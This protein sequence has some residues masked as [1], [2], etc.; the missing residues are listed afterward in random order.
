MSTVAVHEAEAASPPAGISDDAHA[1]TIEIL[2]EITRGGLAGLITGVVV[3]G[4][5]GRLVM[6]L[7]ALLVPTSA[8]AHTEN[9]NVIGAITL[10]GSLALIVFAGL[11]VG[12]IAG[13]VWVMIAPWLPR[14]TGRRM[15]TAAL[16]AG[17]LGAPVL[18]QA[19]NIDFIVLRR[20]PL[21]VA[22]L[23][24]LVLLAGPVLVAA[25]RWLDG[26]LPRPPVRTAIDSAYA[27]VAALG[28]VLTVFLVIPALASSKVAIA[29]LAILLVG[30][31]TLLTWIQRVRGGEPADP[32]L[33]VIVRGALVVAVVTGL[34]VAFVEVRG[35][36]GV[37]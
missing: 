6:R 31:A 23:I 30:F 19:S 7:A 21:V 17:A 27:L 3:G 33:A 16:V 29:G 12:A 22:S 13:S 15:A 9:G 1:P 2:R 10:E 11:A 18:V 35:A 32:G 26:R 24:G 5:G 4:I 36:L 28:T 8:G 37:F 14:S 20:D 34:W 25:E